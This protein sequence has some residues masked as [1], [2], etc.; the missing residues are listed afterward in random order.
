MDEP[1]DPR[2]DSEKV[3]RIQIHDHESL[4]FRF[5]LAYISVSA[6]FL[7]SHPDRGLTPAK[8][9]YH[10]VIFCHPIICVALLEVLF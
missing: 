2:G 7:C 6:P 4:Y 8:F 3:M 5:V 1:G 9:P 10:I